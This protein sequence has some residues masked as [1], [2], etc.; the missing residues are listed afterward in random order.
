MIGRDGLV[1]YKGGM[2]P[3]FFKPLEWKAA[4]ES[5]LEDA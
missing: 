1:A 5:Y 2:G 4:I 3:M